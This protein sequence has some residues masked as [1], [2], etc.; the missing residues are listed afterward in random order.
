MHSLIFSQCRHLTIKMQQLVTLEDARR[1]SAFALDELL[2]VICY[3]S[4]IQYSFIKWMTK[5]TKLHVMKYKI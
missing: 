2:T 3:H 5:R 1:T 4:T